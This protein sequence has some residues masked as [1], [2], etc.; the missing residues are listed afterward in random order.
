MKYIASRAATL[1]LSDGT[2]FEITAG[3]HD[4][5]KFPENVKKHWAF[6]T[7]VSPVDE[8]DLEK[9]QEAQGL[10][11]KVTSLEKKLTVLK[12]QLEERDKTVAAQAGEITALKTQLGSQPDVS[13]QT[14]DTPDKPAD[15]EATKNAKKQQASD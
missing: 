8:A 7:Y 1:S 14:T 15:G 13:D 5:A 10:A 2:Q 6:K 12:T 4:A 3:I 9:E 11:K